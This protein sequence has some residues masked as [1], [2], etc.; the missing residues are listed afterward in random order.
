MIEEKAFGMETTTPEA[1]IINLGLGEPHHSLFPNDQLRDIWEIPKINMYYPS[2]GDINLKEKLIERYYRQNSIDNLIITNGGIGALDFV[3]RSHIQS[4]DIIL[5]PDPGFPPYEQLAKLHKAQAIKYKI[6]LSSNDTLFDWDSLN[7]Q[8]S[9]ETSILLIN[10]PHNPTGKVLSETDRDHLD[11][12]FLEYPKLTIIF[13][14]VYRDLIFN[15]QK[16]INLYEWRE[17]VIFIGSFSK[18]FPIQGARIG[19]VLA[20]TESIEK[21]KPFMHNCIG[22]IS[23][24]GQEVAKKLLDSNISFSH[25]HDKNVSSAIKILDQYGLE[26]ITPQGTFFIFINCHAHS[27]QVCQEL[28]KIGIEAI[29]GVAFGE[30]SHN[31]IRVSLSNTQENIE[32]GMH[33]ICQ[34]IK[35]QQDQHIFVKD[36]IADFIAERGLKHIFGMSGANIEDL[37]FSIKSKEETQVILAK[38]EYNA[39]LMAMSAYLKTNQIQVVYTTSGGGFMNTIPIIAEAYTS[40]IPIVIISGQVPVHFEGKGGFQDTSGKGD[41]FDIVE[42]TRPMTAYCKKIKDSSEIPNTLQEAFAISEI[43]KRPAVI[44]IPKNIFSASFIPTKLIK[45]NEK[46]ESEKTNDLSTLL[47]SINPLTNSC[48]VAGEELRHTDSFEALQ[49]DLEEL[50]IPIIATSA[51]K[52]SFSNAH[53]NF[54]GLIGMMGHQ[55]AEETILQSENIIFLGCELNAINTFGVSPLLEGKNIIIINEFPTFEINNLK[56][57]SVHRIKMNSLRFLKELKEIQPS[58]NLLIETQSITTEKQDEDSFTSENIIASINKTLKPKDDIFVDAGNTGAFCVHHLRSQ[59]LGLFYISL[60]MG[61]MGNSIGAAIGASFF[62][63][64]S[65]RSYVFIGDGSFMIH[66][67]EI[68]TAVEY[69]LPITFFIF[70]DN[71]HG[72]CTLREKVF[73]SEVTNINNFRTT[74]F[75][76]G[77][78]H[79]FQNVESFEIS[80]IQELNNTLQLIENNNK[81]NILSLNI[82]RDEIPPFKI[83]NNKA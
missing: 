40:R 72:M 4:G 56:A 7:Q 69:Q 35:G 23:S 70:N 46:K 31:Y 77:L 21:I 2:L 74:T 61:A 52:G 6:N 11:H 3:F 24:F 42:T 14:E 49:E 66:G 64:P 9:Y 37:L 59:G 10:S 82:G 29:P 47:K 36:Y 16:H 43:E 17:R 38:N 73:N 1:N 53:K 50:N 33:K 39:C 30:H 55:T 65:Q 80:S 8:I 48:L 57:K 12:L 27:S 75:G 13:D 54:K 67:F 78:R 5:I 68:H 26:Y 81:V 32:E 20:P 22:A 44:F 18:V 83:L 79:I 62:N 15:G 58:S 25:F 41:S 34:Y 19:W 51:A 60:G 63:S 28:K 76:N 71:A 45:L